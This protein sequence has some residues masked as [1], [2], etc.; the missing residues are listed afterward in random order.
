MNECTELEAAG[1]ASSVD[2]EAQKRRERKVAAE[3]SSSRIEAVERITIEGVDIAVDS[4][5]RVRIIDEAG[6]GQPDPPTC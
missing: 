5:D 4:T 1:R 3:V 6:A 2:D